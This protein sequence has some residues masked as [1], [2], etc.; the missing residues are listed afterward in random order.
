MERPSQDI[1][2]LF[3]RVH[4]FT[5]ISSMYDRSKYR[6]FRMNVDKIVNL[7][8]NYS[9]NAAPGITALLVF[10]TTDKFGQNLT[11]GDL[12]SVDG[13]VGKMVVTK[14]KESDV[15]TV[16]AAAYVSSRGY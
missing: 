14:V 5:P 7:T 2:K 1:I 12:I 16:R 10:D 9:E 13:V 6:I 11:A 8:Q 4:P 3:G 15:F